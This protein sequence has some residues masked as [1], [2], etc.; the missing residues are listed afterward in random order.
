MLVAHLNCDRKLLIATNLSALS[1]YGNPTS[2]RIS[3]AC[4]YPL[5]IKKTKVIAAKKR[6]K[7]FDIIVLQNISKF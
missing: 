1:R 5:K 4:F 6:L 3:K 7:R 2:H